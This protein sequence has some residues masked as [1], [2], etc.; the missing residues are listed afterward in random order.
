MDEVNTRHATVIY[1]TSEIVTNDTRLRRALE[2]A[3][4]K[5]A[6]S[7]KYLIDLLQLTQGRTRTNYKTIRIP[8][9]VLPALATEAGVA[10]KELIYPNQSMMPDSSIITAL[11]AM[12]ENRR[13]MLL[14]EIERQTQGCWTAE[15]LPRVNDRVAIVG[16]KALERIDV[17]GL[18]AE[19]KAVFEQL[20]VLVTEVKIRRN[21]KHPAG[22]S[23]DELEL[24][25]EMTNV[26]M[27]YYLGYLGGPRIMSK[28]PLVDDLYDY[29]MLFKAI[30]P[31]RLVFFDAV[32]R[33]A[34]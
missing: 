2:K 22:I 14:T 26:T 16:K 9:K 29:Y 6:V 4:E 27:R 32:I 20:D 34:V 24:L 1:G 10:L 8:Y 5:G 31:S 19:Q 30:V 18:T 15:K 23:S 12:P 33:G 11:G 7:R 17:E 21:L 25:S 28:V 13:E 3:L